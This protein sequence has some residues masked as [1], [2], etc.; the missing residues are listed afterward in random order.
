MYFPLHLRPWLE[1]LHIH[2]CSFLN[3][4]HTRYWPV[5]QGDR[6]A[7]DAVSGV[8]HEAQPVGEDLR[9]EP[10][11]LRRLQ[12]WEA[13]PWR[14]VPC[15]LWTQQVERWAPVGLPLVP[16]LLKGWC[17]GLHEPTKNV[18]GCFSFSKTFLTCRVKVTTL[19]MAATPISYLIEQR[20]ESDLEEL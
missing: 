5:E 20:L 10:A 8:P 3:I 2:P 11:A 15:W 18:F 1:R 7:G 13:L 6:A 4:I 19:E 16:N 17:E 9:G 14:P 12:L